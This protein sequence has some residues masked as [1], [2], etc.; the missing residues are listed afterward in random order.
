MSPLLADQYETLQERRR[1]VPSGYAVPSPLHVATGYLADDS[2]R[3]FPDTQ[4]LEMHIPLSFVSAGSVKLKAVRPILAR[5][6]QDGD[7]VVAKNETLS[8][9]GYGQDPSQ[10]LD[11]FQEHVIHY[12]THYSTLNEDEL[13][14]D[15]ILLTRPYADI[16]KKI[17]G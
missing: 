13:A 8:V 9:V 6:Y 17:E 4:R 10:A 14:E 3:Y 16:L 7:M 15:A 5:I 1:Q 2:F 12:S 11:D